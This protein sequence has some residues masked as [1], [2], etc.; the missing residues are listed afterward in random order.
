MI[1]IY[2]KELEGKDPKEIIVWALKTFGIENIALS[3]SFGAEDQMLTDILL[4]VDKNAN[5]FTLDTGRL[6]QETYDVWEKTLSKY[7]CE[8][9]PLFPDH[10][11]VEDLEKNF[12]PNL[13]YHSIENRKLCCKIRKINPLA[14]KLSK[15]KAWICGLRKAQ[16]ITRTDIEVIEWDSVFS[17]YKIN[18][19][20]L[21]SEDD[22]WEYIR[23]NEVP[24]NSL[25]DKGF[26]SIGCAPCTRAIKPGEDVRAGRWFWEDK[27]K[28][29]CGLH[30]K[31]G[32]LK[33]SKEV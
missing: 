6:P 26:P 18:P 15:L 13:F 1:E 9:E 11:E 20:I 21:L 8:I 32:K 24:Y 17:L 2:K 25:H 16:S 12:G 27:D 33:K 5:I 3:T 10:K 31:N 23:K 19:L 29:E 22:V 30:L 28:K 7:N 4:K 14:K